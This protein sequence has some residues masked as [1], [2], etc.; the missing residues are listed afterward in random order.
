MFL[1]ASVMLLMSYVDSFMIS[2]YLD[3]YQVGIYNACINLSM[4]ITFIPMAIG[5]FISPK[6]SKA[7]SNNENLKVK[8]IFK[9]STIIIVI[10]TLPI[11]LIMYLYGDLF[12]GLFGSEF[13]I[14]TTTL[15]LTNVAF[16]SEALLGPVGF[17]LN[18][19]DNQHVFMKIL[20]I[21]LLINVVFNFLLI[22]IYGINGAAIAL[23]L[24]MF[25]WTMGSFIVLKRK[26]I[27]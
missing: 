12:L 18:M 6:V 5:G 9:D 20:L 2:Y 14:A 4:L 11:F 7:F 16:L 3:E 10:I 24:S 23:L 13:I 25:F 26:E 27:I 19:T 17:I 15:L 1:A 21:S 22:P 8:K